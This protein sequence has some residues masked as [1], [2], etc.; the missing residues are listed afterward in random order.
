MYAR[1]S[2]LD[3]VSAPALQGASAKAEQRQRAEVE[4]FFSTFGRRPNGS[5]GTDALFPLDI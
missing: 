5:A 1:D 3:I 4:N 2:A